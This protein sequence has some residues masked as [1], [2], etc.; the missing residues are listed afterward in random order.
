MTPSA[1]TYYR[2]LLRAYPRPFRDRFGSD[3][4]ELFA[5]VYRTRAAGLTSTALAR[6]WIRT[7]VETVAQGLAE[8]LPQRR[9]LP[10]GVH[11]QRGP[12]AMT[13]VLED[14][15]HA[16]RALRQ[17][18]ALSAVI[19]LTLALAIGANSA[20]F[21]VVNAVLLRPLPYKNP[22]RVVMLY[23]VDRTGADRLMSL[24]DVDDLRERLTTLTGLSVM[25]TQTA[26]L[27]GVGEPDRLRAGFVSADFFAAL[28]VQPVMGR[29][30]ADGE[31]L[32]HAAK[33][34]ILDYDVWRTRF[35]SD[36]RMI[37][38][39]LIL[40]NEPHQV[41]GVLP[42]QF[43]FPIAENEIWL[44]ITSSPI[45]DAK[46]D[47]RYLM[48]F[49][50]VA[51]GVAFSQ[52]EAE[53]KQAAQ[54]LAQAYPETNAN[55]TMRFEE[56]HALGVMF[57]S[58][59]LR[60]LAG[61]IGFVLLIACANIAN[62]LLARASGRQREIAVRAAL[63]ASRGRIVRQLLLESVLLAGAGGAIGLVLSAALTDAI[64]TLLPTLPRSEFVRPDQT[65][66]AFTAA[67]SVVTGLLFGLAPA[68]RLSRPNLR[69]TLTESARSSDGPAT[70]RLRSILVVA[71]LALS[72]VLVAGAGLFIQSVNRLLSVDLGY[73]PS[74]L[75]TLE[76]RL[77]RNKYADP[78]QQ[79]GFHHRVLERIAALPGVRS[80]AFARAFPQSGNG[81]FVGYWRDGEATPTRE[82]MPRAQLNTVSEGYFGTLGIPILAGRV[83]TAADAPQAPVAVIVNQ[84]L[85]ERLWPGTSAVGQRLRS[86]DIPGVALVMGV[87]GNTR[88]QLLSQPI[89]PQIY[90]C[91]SQQPGIFATIA[92]KT[93]DEPMALARSVQQAIWSLDP[94]QP[95]WKIRTAESMI[96]A[97]VQRER[98]VML[99]MSCAAGLALLLAGLGT[100]SVLAYTVQRRTREVGVRMAL[101]ATRGE[102]VR[103]L[104]AQT[105]RLT[106][107]GVT[108]GL[109]AT[110]ALRGVVAAQLYEVS[111]RD[112]FTF[113][114]TALVLGGVSLI[115]TWLP[116]RR[117]IDVDP[118][119]AL[120]TD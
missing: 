76:Y 91:L 71:E 62:L 69:A 11:H 45:Q 49:A 64:L 83:C 20:I 96:S 22:E 84:L 65:V 116:T 32:P 36:P 41:I 8:R 120:R 9:R 35:G 117:A 81:A 43:E 103:L 73:D 92:V 107:A 108:L 50:R 37:G 94:D 77:P 12:S 72:L 105:A 44:P 16:L 111:P 53:L 114:A 13:L 98:F 33:T 15:R 7:T 93:S 29:A 100:Y 118:V 21:T 3:L 1:T 59:N 46:R 56:V 112:P 106:A 86:P 57:V 25:G 26:N 48:T 54:A 97:T 52:A 115:A 119:I 67:L 99:L 80:V 109:I 66:V 70:A 82:T 42:P 30:F 6:F 95:M 113:A 55:W 85:A 68:L 110:W 88:P 24:P 60:L 31:D 51:D 4:E 87:V 27:T 38:R 34:A 2:L 14:L 102:I 75:L 78:E 58:R 79:I 39:T 40:N 89:A 17:Q 61:A 63:G 18:H 104:L 101:G 23:T 19:V 10:L 90:G 5:D 28:G 74:N 47:S